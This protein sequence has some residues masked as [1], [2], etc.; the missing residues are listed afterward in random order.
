[1]VWKCQGSKISD[2]IQYFAKTRTS[3]E[4]YGIE[5]NIKKAFG[6][7]KLYEGAVT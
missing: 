6:L 4:I 7:E 1:M 3:I 5:T 2:S